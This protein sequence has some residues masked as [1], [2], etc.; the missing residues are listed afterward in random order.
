MLPALFTTV[1]LLAQEPSIV[2]G[3]NYLVSRDGD[4]PHAE[5]MMAVN[6]LDPQNLVAASITATRPD[7]G[8]ACRTYAS[9]DG[10][11]T[12]RH[13]DFA[14][15]VEFSGFDPQ[16]VFTPRGD[17]IFAAISV[18][19]IKDD[20]G[21]PRGSLDLYHSTDGG[22][23]WARTQQICC[24]H[25]HPQMSVDTTAGRHAGRVYIGTLH[26]Y[27]FYR[28]GVFRSDDGRNFTGP[29]EVSNGG[30]ELGLNVM[31]MP[32]LSDGTLVVTMI[33]FEFLPG[34]APE[35]GRTELGVWVATSSDGG[36]TFTKRQRVQGMVFDVEPTITYVPVPHTAADPSGRSPNHLY[37]VWPDTRLGKPRILFSRSTD[38]GKTWSAPGPIAGDV[39]ASAM[40]Y[41]PTIA[42]NK[43]GVVGVTWFDTR[44]SADGSE[45][46][47]YFAASVDGGRTFLPA[48]RVT[49]EPSR[50]AGR[51]NNRPM[52]N[53]YK[54]GGKAQLAM[55]SASTRWPSGGDYLGMTA[56][57][58]G[59]FLPLWSDARTGTFQ[60]YTAPIRV[61]V[62]LTD[63]EKKR[64]EM[65]AVWE[66]PAK[67]AGDPAKRVQTDLLE[68][69]DFVFDPTIREDDIV[70]LRVRLKN[71]TEASIHAPVRLEVLGFGGGPEPEK[72]STVV[73]I[74]NALNGKK[75]AGAEFVFDEALGEERTLAPS[76]LSG[77]VLIRMRVPDPKRDPSLQFRL[78]GMTD[79]MPGAAQ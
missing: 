78:T 42:V 57:R 4:V 14:E 52:P 68:R 24:S 47:M 15:Q 10:G 18:H 28:V 66:A 51:G 61:R 8:W 45:F 67:K 71:R 25:D 77:P 20:E 49:T 37:M 19:S 30:G 5:M 27:P 1:S 79:P 43:D 7:G 12:W 69:V 72:E 6:P 63:E 58:R 59:I 40:Q 55:I 29:V 60:M 3:P 2:V 64:A 65:R 74:L 31:S 9:R 11:A 62:P 32:V 46:H 73:E 53:V 50:P 23:E 33:D 56:D 17:A 26:D 13:R 41:Q 76:M 70:E 38:R 39:P 48:E 36:L 34:R 75:G 54:I 44:H 35:K 21:K 22:F 16:V